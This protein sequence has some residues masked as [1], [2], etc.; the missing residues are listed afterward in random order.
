[1][2]VTAFG[3]YEVAMLATVGGKQVAVGVE[4]FVY[5]PAGR[6]I[7][8][9]LLLAAVVMLP[10]RPWRRWRS[11]VRVWKWGPPALAFLALLLGPPF[12]L[13]M[14]VIVVLAQ[15]VAAAVT[16]SVWGGFRQR[17]RTLGALT[18]YAVNFAIGVLA[19]VFRTASFEGISDGWKDLLAASVMPALLGSLMWYAPSMLAFVALRNVYSAGRFLGGLGVGLVLTALV[20]G[21]GGWLLE[22]EAF[23]GVIFGIMALF[24]GLIYSSAVFLI[25]SLNVECRTRVI[26]VFG[27][28]AGQPQPPG[29]GLSSV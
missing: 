10:F 4:P 19:G 25:L 29:V 28:N 5:L 12:P 3:R 24:V 21:V 2:P 26:R 13:D 7:L 6:I 23:A 16:I 15:T 22:G 11:G 1:M 9:A 27:L 20:A 18:G 17:Q 14:L 8:F